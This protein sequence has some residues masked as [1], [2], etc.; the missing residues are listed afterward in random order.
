MVSL[1]GFTL[2]ALVAFGVLAVQAAGVADAESRATARSM[3][4]VE[5][6]D[7]D[8]QGNP[9][10]FHLNWSDGRNSHQTMIQADSE[11]FVQGSVL[12]IR[13]DPADPG[14]LVF[15][16]GHEDVPPPGDMLRRA[17]F[18][19]AGIYGLGLVLVLA[20]FLLNRHAAS[21][22]E[23]RWQVRPLILEYR[24][25]GVRW[26]SPYLKLVPE[27]G[28]RP[29]Y[30]RVHWDPAVD[31]RAE[32]L[33]AQVR[34]GGGPFRRAVVITGDGTRLWPAGRLRRR[35]PRGWEESDR[36]LGKPYWHG[37]GWVLVA[38]ITGVTAAG[39]LRL[40]ALLYLVPV[41]A[42]LVGLLCLMWGWYGGRPLYRSPGYAPGVEPR[43]GPPQNPRG[44]SPRRGRRKKTPPRNR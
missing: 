12:P 21:A 41:L 25:K 26:F 33:K 31:E 3:A 36:P 43:P 28:A 40:D 5:Y 9:E 8:G 32:A 13:Y 23:A 35:T 44:S 2:G 14:G 7:F 30:Q 27:R 10:M 16:A 39:L 17:P 22:A 29:Y 6:I 11:H 1:G 38:S 20:R 37:P 24:T 4:T 42:L 15:P 19:V 34:I 18:V